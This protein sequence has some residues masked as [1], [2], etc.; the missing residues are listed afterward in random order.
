MFFI[1]F[2]FGVFFGFFSRRSKTN[3]A[4]QSLGRSLLSRS[5]R[6]A[7]EA[8]HCV[9][10]IS[11]WPSRA[12]QQ[13]VCRS[14]CRLVCPCVSSVCSPPPPVTC[15]CGAILLLLLLFLL[16]PKLSYN[17]AM[18]SSA[19]QHLSASFSASAS[20]SFSPCGLFGWSLLFAFKLRTNHLEILIYCEKR[21]RPR[22]TIK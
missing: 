13:G 5:A 3:H 16:L 18:S 2:F 14:V 6:D 15:R 21:S 7:L 4:P 9:A 19:L 8:W 1:W 11:T 17:F 12:G 10:S 22:E 20:S